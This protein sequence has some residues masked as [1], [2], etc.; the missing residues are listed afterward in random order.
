MDNT[1]ILDEF[2]MF[3]MQLV[4]RMFFVALHQV[5]TL[6]DDLVGT[7]SRDNQV[8]SLSSCKANKEVHLADVVVDAIFNVVISL[9]FRRRGEGKN[10]PP[11]Q[12]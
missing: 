3:T 6:D 1:R 7:R 2:E 8:K 12:Q 9:R 4:S 11:L 5:I 10:N